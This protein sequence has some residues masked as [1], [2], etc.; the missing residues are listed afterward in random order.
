MMM[1]MNL[2][3]VVA[4]VAIVAASSAVAETKQETCTL[5]GKLAAVIMEKRQD[6]VDMSSL[7][8]IA[9]SEIVKRMVIFAYD[10]PRYSSEDYKRT[11]V[12][13]FANEAMGVCYG[14]DW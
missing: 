6:G 4:A 9:E 3:A 13:D 2:K 8:E 10:T 1:M 7:M 14:S 5:I 11:A 12:Q